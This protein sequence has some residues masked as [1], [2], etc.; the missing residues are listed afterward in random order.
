MVDKVRAGVAR[1]LEAA[2][3]KAHRGHGLADRGQQPRRSLPSRSR[4]STRSTRRW[5]RPPSSLDWSRELAEP[6]P[7][8]LLPAQADHRPL[9]RRAVDRGEGLAALTLA[10]YRRDLTLYA[11]GWPRSAG[12]ALD[13]TAKPTCW[14][15]SSPPRRQRA[16]T[17]NRRDRLQALLPL[18][19]ARAPHHGD[20]TLRLLSGE[21][22][23]RAP[24]TLTEA[25]V[26]ALLRPTPPAAGPA[27]PHHARADV[28]QRPARQRTGGLKS[29]HLGLTEGVLR[30]TGRNA[31]ERLV[32]F[33]EEARVWIERYLADAAA[34]L[35]GRA[36]PSDAFRHGAWRAMTRQMFW[37]M[38]KAARWR[39]HAGAAVAA[40]AAPRVR[41]A[42][43]QPRRGICAQCRCCSAMPTSPRPPST[44][45]WRASASKLLRAA[46]FARLIC[47]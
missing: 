1:P 30:I 43:A 15:T 27:R 11:T 33:G 46:S 7:C 16:T 24:K 41:D 9:R 13:E 34:D 40:H 26:E 38:V 36:R 21:A 31:K 2:D 18:G 37:M 28:C 22:P 20:P 12:R 39:R 45:M 10:A 14:A 23:L 44:R 17:A 3:V 42:P 19:T 4:P 6:A 35:G 25:Q 5:S 47:A 29:V 8:R 32:P